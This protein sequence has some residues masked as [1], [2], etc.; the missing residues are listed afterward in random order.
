MIFYFKITLKYIRK[1]KFSALDVVESRGKEMWLVSYV[2]C[3][4]IIAQVFLIWWSIFLF[5][6]LPTLKLKIIIIILPTLR[7]KTI[8]QTARTTKKLLHY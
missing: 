4:D 2:N 6:D 7:P 8:L 1:Q 5:L 3:D